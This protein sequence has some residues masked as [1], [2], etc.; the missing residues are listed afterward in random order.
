MKKRCFLIVGLIF[1]VACNQSVDL[2]TSSQPEDVPKKQNEETPN[3]ENISLEEQFIPPNFTIN[4]LEMDVQEKELI[5][6][7][8]FTLSQNLY[9]LLRQHEDYYFAIE[10]PEVFRE[11]TGIYISEPVKGPIPANKNLSYQTNIHTK[12]NKKLSASLMK[13]LSGEDASYNLL[14]LNSEYVPVHEFKDIQWYRY[15][16]KNEG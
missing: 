4:Q 5:I 7:L 3:E 8:Y 10:Y 13:N 14:I 16:N 6:Q 15:V 11:Y 2:E 9:D 1:L 12:W